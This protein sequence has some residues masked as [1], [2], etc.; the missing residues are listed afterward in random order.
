MLK[1][2][3]LA[4]V[5]FSLLVSCKTEIKKETSQLTEKDK[6][7]PNIVVIYVDDLGYGDIGVNGAIGASTPNIDKLANNGIN[8][9]DAHCS[10]AT[11]TPSRYSLLT[12]SYAFRN[13]AQ[14]LQGDAPL[15][16]N[17]DEATLPKMLQKN[18]YKTA[19]VGKW[20][21][22]LGDG[23]VDWNKE[24]APGPREIGFDYSFL[25]PATGDR[26]PAVYLENQ[27][28]M[29]LDPNDPLKVSYKGKIGNL[30]TGFENPDLLRQVPDGQHNKTIVNG[31]SRIGFMSGGRS[32]WWVDEEFPD[33]LVG[34]AKKFINENRDT[35]FFLYLA[36]H[37]IHVPRLPNEKFLGKSSMGVRG[38]VIEQMDWC[39]GEVVKYLEELGLDRN[40][41]V[42]FSSDNGPVLNDGYQD[43]SVEKLGNHKPAGPFRGGKYSALEAG[44]R[45]P[46]IAYWPGTISSKTSNALWSQV[47]LYASI[48]ALTGHD[49]DDREAPDSFNMLDVILGKTEYGRK[50]MLEE[51]FTLSLRLGEWKY[52]APTKRN[53]KWIDNKGVESGFSSEPQ[54]FNL[55]EDISET[56]NVAK[57]NETLVKEIQERIKMIKEKGS[58]LL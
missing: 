1:Q 54:L 41:L 27:K 25:I 9:T 16:I 11:C 46:T 57:D 40:T 20:H 6:Q 22:G 52:I 18:G 31:I 13:N 29:N 35:P 37:D 19:V 55:R 43:E 14:I 44:T 23:E 47:D 28:V 56:K 12:G 26:V 36:Y 10:A 7:K 45:M 48:A 24:V 21:L 3:L 58:R 15:L 50:E 5:I 2:F 17:S 4:V 39:T 8:F 51:S 49:L 38:D 32:A 33:V 53:P 30:P 42:L 34:K